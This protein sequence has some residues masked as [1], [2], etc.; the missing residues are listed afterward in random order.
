MNIKLLIS[1][2]A[3]ISLQASAMSDME[4]L[5]ALVEKNGTS[6]FAHSSILSSL[7]SLFS[8]SHSHEVSTQLAALASAAIQ[9]GSSAQA[10]DKTPAISRAIGS[11]PTLPS[12]NATQSSIDTVLQL[13][14]N[15]ETQTASNTS[16][17]AKVLRIGI[18]A[19]FTL[20]AAGDLIVNYVMLVI[21]LK[22][23]QVKKL[24]VQFL[25]QPQIWV[26]WEREHIKLHLV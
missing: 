22:H 13:A 14:Q 18:G 9:D 10:K 15:V 6:T 20:F 4:K 23:L 26:F 8:H 2:S 7:S 3:L 12:T 1:C 11:L 21:I 24:P 16:V 5:V 17:K 19:A 25:M